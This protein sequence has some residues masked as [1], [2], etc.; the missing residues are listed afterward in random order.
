MK[1]FSFTILLVLATISASFAGP[2][3][4]GEWQIQRSAAGHESTQ[5]CTFVQTDG[6]LS[7]TCSSDDGPVQL[8]GKIEGKEVTWGFRT[9]SQAG[10]ITVVYKGTVDSETTMSGTVSALE[11]G[12]DG[13]F[14]AERLK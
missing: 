2:S 4:A 5:T 7:G 1:S 13:D 9:N 12:I 3:I 11:M 6:E 14:S 10:M 8:S